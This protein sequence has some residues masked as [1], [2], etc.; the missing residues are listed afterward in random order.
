MGFEAGLVTLLVL[1]DSAINLFIIRRLIIE[2]LLRKEFFQPVAEIYCN[3]GQTRP[4]LRG[5]KPYLHNR[6]LPAITPP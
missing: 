1:T 6:G 5:S 4:P 3:R 2:I